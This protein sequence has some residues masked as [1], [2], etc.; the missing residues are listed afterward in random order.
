MFF[1]P[2]FPPLE[3]DFLSLTPRYVRPPSLKFSKI[4]L[5]STRRQFLTLFTFSKNFY[6]SI[7]YLTQHAFR[8]TWN[9]PFSLLWQEFNFLYGILSKRQWKNEEQNISSRIHFLNLY[10]PASFHS[11]FTL[12]N[13]FV[14][15]IWS[16]DE[17][18]PSVIQVTNKSISKTT[19]GV[20]FERNKELKERPKN[21]R[22]L[23][24]RGVKYVKK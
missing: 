17:E 9:L 24:S 16:K 12:S 1:F 13:I 19:S 11:L 2:G 18:F 21:E 3:F 10:F 20:K 5:A 7:P 23:Y 14:H 15:K 8:T 22:L 6:E 4:S